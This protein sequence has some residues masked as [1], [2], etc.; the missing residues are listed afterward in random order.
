MNKTNLFLFSSGIIAVGLLMGFVL[1]QNKKTDYIKKSERLRKKT[2]REDKN[3]VS[4]I[5]IFHDLIK[6]Y[7]LDSSDPEVFIDLKDQLIKEG[8]HIAAKSIL[9]ELDRNEYTID[10][11]IRVIS[12]YE[13]LISEPL[14][15]SF[16]EWP[17]DPNSTPI[18]IGHILPYI[19]VFNLDISDKKAQKESLILL[20]KEK[21]ITY[22]RDL[23][24]NRLENL[25]KWLKESLEEKSIEKIESILQR[26]SKIAEEEIKIT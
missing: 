7:H 4:Y 13:Q 3:I 8:V 11:A 21:F 26:I 18:Y 23:I 17:E 15:I 19:E 6:K 12:K 16:E 20:V 14:C 2:H 25:I 22:G 10:K 24:L 1:R 5:S 9:N